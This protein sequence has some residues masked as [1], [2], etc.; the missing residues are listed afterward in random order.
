VTYT[1]TN[2]TWIGTPSPDGNFFADPDWSPQPPGETS[3]GPLDNAIAGGAVSLL[4]FGSE[5]IGGLDLTGLTTGLLLINGQQLA[6]GTT[7][8]STVGG[9]LDAAGVDS[10]EVLAPGG[11]LTA[12]ANI[13]A[14]T[15]IVNVSD[16]GAYIWEGAGSAASVTQTVD[17][18]D[19]QALGGGLFDVYSQF[20]GTVAF[21]LG[22]A[23]NLLPGGPSAPVMISAPPTI[24]G[25]AIDYSTTDSLGVVT[26]YTLNL[27]PG[28]DL[29]QI[30]IG[31]W[32]PTTGVTV[33]SAAH[34]DFLNHPE[35][36]FLIENTS[37]AV[38]VG[39][40]QGGPA[41]YQLVSGLGPE[42]TFVGDGDFSG[43]GVAGF[44]IQN[45]AGAVD[46]GQ[47]TGGQASFTQVSALGPE[48]KFV[49]V[50][51]FMADGHADF[52]IENAAG[53]VDVGEVSGGSTAYTQVSALGPE[54]K[55]VGTGDFFGDGRDEFLIENAGGAIDAG[56]V[57]GGQAVYTQ[58]SAL[59]PEW[60]FR[61]TGDFLG[62]GHSDVLIENA[63]GAVD[64]G[65]VSGGHLAYTQIA[66]LGPDWKF[67]GTGDFLHEG[68]DQFLIENA[69]GAVD[70]GDWT[71]GAIHFTQ[72]AA[73][74]PEW[75]FH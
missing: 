65:E 8:G 21:A 18:F 56:E 29:S 11:T 41:A 67:V 14:A 45:A 50:G 64:I 13:T 72:V 57:I 1:G 70:V 58:V 22:S 61:G 12:G 26:H 46:I 59:G 74:G 6:V 36:D 47:V 68:H 4:V 55:F 35:S 48:W 51:D 24:V 62:D 63:A 9:E 69:S 19:P 25:D 10:L 7:A 49:G 73:L 60:A 2:M 3:P 38:V 27:A 28:T 30:G 43:D 5:T 20:F 52:L 15:G 33:S 44:L 71:N 40:V 42:W 53:A 34:D 31:A 54:W 32:S 75:S 37:G 39:E 66:G 17:L 23:V 16:Q